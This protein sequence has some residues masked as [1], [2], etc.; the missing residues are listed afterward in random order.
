M[1]GPV[2]KQMGYERRMPRVQQG[3][4]RVL[5]PLHVPPE[6]SLGQGTGDV[7]SQGVSGSGVSHRWRSDM[8]L[9][10]SGMFKTCFTQ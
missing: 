6:V 2:S 8:I 5:C 3:S 1:Q 10:A 4:S 9:C 7:D